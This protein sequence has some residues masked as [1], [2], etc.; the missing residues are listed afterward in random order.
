M[1]I[2]QAVSG[3]VKASETFSMEIGGELFKTVVSF[4]S[5]LSDRHSV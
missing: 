5:D 4:L 3:K 2:L 1:F